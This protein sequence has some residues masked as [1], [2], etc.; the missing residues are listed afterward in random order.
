[1]DDGQRVKNGGITLCTD[2]YNTKEVNILREAL[3]TNFN[4]E[5]TIH[6]KSGKNDAT[7]ERI[8]IKKEG[9]EDIK[10]SLLSHMHESMY[11]KVNQ[12]MPIIQDSSD[13]ENWRSKC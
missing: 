4:L 10:P 12:E 6:L 2:S 13:I 1:M 9:F 7:Y 5:T 3:K 8:Y 11:Y